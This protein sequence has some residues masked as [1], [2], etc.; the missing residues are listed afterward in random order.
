MFSKSIHY[1]TA[2]W[3][4]NNVQ[5]ESSRSIGKETISSFHMG[6]AFDSSDVVIQ[7]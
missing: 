2:F 6:F 4:Q 7:K 5:A 1:Q 3:Y